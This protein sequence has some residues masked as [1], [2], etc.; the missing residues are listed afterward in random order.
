MADDL[1][2]HF[3]GVADQQ[4]AL[5][6]S[7]RVEPR[8]CDGGPS[9]LLPNIGDG[10][11]VSGKE[12]VGR[13]LRGGCDIAERMHANLQLLGRVS[14]LPAGLAVEIDERTEAPRFTADD[15]DHQRKSELARPHERF[16]GAADPEPYRE[17]VLHRPR[18]DALACQRRPILARPVNMLVVAD[19]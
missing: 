3:V 13:L 4:R 7:L 9:A 19:L 2:Y 15:G 14:C 5:W 17:G 12:V 16:R 8:A 6:T 10:A 18:V 11:G 1:L